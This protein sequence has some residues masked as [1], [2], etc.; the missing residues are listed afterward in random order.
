MAA[1]IR[2]TF[3]NSFFYSLYLSLSLFLSSSLSFSLSTSISLCLL[4][5]LCLS[6]LLLSLPH[7]YFVYL[8][9]FFCTTRKFICCKNQSCQSVSKP[10]R[11]LFPEHCSPK[12]YPAFEKALV[13]T[14]F[15]VVL[16]VCSIHTVLMHRTYDT[17]TIIGQNDTLPNCNI[18]L[19][20]SLILTICNGLMVM[21]KES[22]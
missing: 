8:Y 3:F 15:K 19:A 20:Y 12:L 4:F 13:S 2:K 22:Y 21:A 9:F 11:W 10:G 18:A 7:C 14:S 5:T 1:K 16:S 17:I 6:S